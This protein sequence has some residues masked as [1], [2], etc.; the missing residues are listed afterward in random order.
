MLA[1]PTS[2]ALLAAA[3][4]VTATPA[5]AQQAPP[6]SPTGLSADILAM[7]CAPALA[8]EPPPKPLRI[9]GGQSSFARQA[10]SASDL[11]TINA[12]T[13]NGIEVG[14]EYFVR[15]TLTS[16]GAPISR[17]APATIQTTGWIRVYAVDDEM[18]L[19]TVTHSC[20]SIDAG[21]YLEPLVLRLMPTPSADRGKP[22]RD[23][24]GRVMPGK[25]V[26]ASFGKGD[27]FI[28]NRGTDFGITPGAQFV[29]YRDKKQAE[30]FLYEL[31]EAMA[32][33]VS[34]DW[35]TL[36]VTL[37]RNAIQ[38]GD[39]AGMRTKNLK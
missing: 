37:S 31:G 30:N 26:R 39:Y 6:P 25:D 17:K 5:A 28:L 22:E 13:R 14:Q 1:R 7:A 36:L 9:T 35:S 33:S 24:Y 29:L 12:G 10:Y 15:R 23:N 34:A 20:D 18:S 4:L 16:R 3:L 11:V 21:D 27:F 32:V 2:A 38:A 8:Y 19:A